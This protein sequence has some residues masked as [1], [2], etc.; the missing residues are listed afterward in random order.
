MYA[1]LYAS[2]SRLI[3]YIVHQPIDLFKLFYIC[4]INKVLKNVITLIFIKTK[5][6]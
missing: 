6:T 2:L 1:V 4:W 5:N 3:V